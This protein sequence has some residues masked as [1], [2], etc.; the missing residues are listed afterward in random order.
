MELVLTAIGSL[1]KYIIN[2]LYTILEKE[3][4]R[5]R[6]EVKKKQFPSVHWDD[7][8]S[9][10]YFWISAV[11]DFSVCFSLSNCIYMNTNKTSAQKLVTEAGND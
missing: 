11:H 3:R 2:E 5:E 10:L 9:L 4:E 8:F 1:K 7:V 6:D